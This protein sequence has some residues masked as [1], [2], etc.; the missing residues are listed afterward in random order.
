MKNDPS[1]ENNS[2]FGFYVVYVGCF[3]LLPPVTIKN[4]TTL[5]HRFIPE[6]K[7]QDFRTKLITNTNISQVND[8]S[9]LFVTK[10]V[11][12]VKTRISQ[13]QPRKQYLSR[14]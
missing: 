6:T 11:D 1:F 2:N 7:L 13:T 14:K 3:D 12:P 4:L 10:H 5:S 8:D 9:K